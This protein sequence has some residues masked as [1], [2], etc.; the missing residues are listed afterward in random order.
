MI[1]CFHMKYKSFSILFLAVSLVFGHMTFSD[2][3]NTATPVSK[4]YWIQNIPEAA[5]IND[6]SSIESDLTELSYSENRFAILEST[7]QQSRELLGKNRTEIEAYIAKIEEM[8]RDTEENINKSSGDKEQLEKD[9]LFLEKEIVAMSK[10]QEETKKYIKKILIENYTSETEEK[11][12]ISLYWILLEKTFGSHTSKRETLHILQN[13]ASQLL[14]R[15]NSTERELSELKTSLS[16]KIQTK[17]KILTRLENY[18]EELSNTKDIKKE[19]LAKT[20]EEQSIQR[21]IE[22]VTIKKQTLAVKIEEK[23]AEYEK[24]LQSKV[25]QYDCQTRSSGVCVWM[26]G[27]VQAEKD[28]INNKVVVNNWVWPSVPEKGFWYHFRDQKYFTALNQHHT[29]LD[30][31]IS[32]WMPIHSIGDGYILITQNPT[33]IFPGLIIIKHPAG[34][35]SMYTGVVPGDRTVFSQVKS[36]DIIAT[37]RE[38]TEHSGKNNVHIELYENGSQ[39]DL[40][41]KMDTSGLSAN[42]IPARYGWKYI[43]DV[44]KKTDTP[45]ISLLKKQIGF[46]YLEWETEGERQQSLL[47][48]YASSTFRNRNIWVEESIAESID[49]TFVLCVGL[50]ESTLGK[51]LTT[52]GNIGNVWNTDSGARRDYDGPRAGIR[53]ISSVVNNRYLWK[54]MSIDQLSGWGNPIGPIYASSQTNWHENI[55]KCMSA[56]KWKY[57]WNKSN[58]RLTKASLL[59]YQKEWFSSK[60]DT[61]K[62]SEKSV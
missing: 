55:V 50:A 12:D 30:I 36:G 34:L 28:L 22:K 38:Y 19:V 51:N 39:V 25:T 6:I 26:R 9:I 59:M 56:I 60:I 2:E 35:M 3:E 15:Q 52:E 33:S 4:I 42:T 62:K 41:D 13:T 47:D 23:F 53:A 7:F 21:K 32:P 40:L 43:D 24:S 14:E 29:W 16:K 61:E 11:T 17:T 31:L 5:I 45:N 10:R 18:Q 54:Y 57:V 20:I 1:I 48:N 8:Q 27:Y 37:S 58:F 46:F 49:P 44:S